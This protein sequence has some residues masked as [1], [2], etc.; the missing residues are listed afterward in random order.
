MQLQERISAQSAEASDGVLVGQ[1]IAGD[2]RTFEILVRR[3][4]ALLFDYT[5]RYMRDYDQACDVLQHVWLQP[6][7][8]LSTLRT[9]KPLKPWLL[10]VAQNRCL[11]RWTATLRSIVLPPVPACSGPTVNRL[12][13]LLLSTNNPLSQ[14]KVP[15][16]LAHSQAERAERGT[17]WTC[18]VR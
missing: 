11:R 15:A 12:S 18:M 3:Y 2:E 13:L 8:S 10:R 4:S 5:Y 16:S 9:G 7:L 1:I 17:R 6:Y 14:R